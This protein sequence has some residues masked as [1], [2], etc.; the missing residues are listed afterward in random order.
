MT[1]HSTGSGLMKS[2]LFWMTMLT[3]SFL[4]GFLVIAPLMQLTRSRGETAPT[5]SLG[6]AGQKP[7]TVTHSAAAVPKQNVEP[8]D[9]VDITADRTTDSNISVQPGADPTESGAQ[10]ESRHEDSSEAPQT[11]PP[12]ATDDE[13]SSRPS[14]D[15][16]ERASD[17]PTRR[18][19]SDRSEQPALSTD[20]GTRTT[21]TDNSEPVRRSS[22]RSRGTDSEER[23]PARTRED[24]D[25]QKGEG[26]D[27]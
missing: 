14:R 20:E 23:R 3:A 25:I 24:G 2:A 18:S 16:A 11:V 8:D 15:A 12:G 7:P 4:L 22:R 13:R 21:A 5:P 17:R 1:D 9:P 26:I 19:T 6:N 27:R 10:P